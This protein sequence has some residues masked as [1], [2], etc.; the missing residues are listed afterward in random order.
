[1]LVIPQL[2]GGLLMLLPE[3]DSGGVDGN[4][5]ASAQPQFVSKDRSAGEPCRKTL[6]L[7]CIGCGEGDGL[8]AA[9]GVDR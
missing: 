8:F 6:G 3:V 9:L 1:M 4:P 7:M 2:D 5:L